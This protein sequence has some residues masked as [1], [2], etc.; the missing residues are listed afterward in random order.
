MPQVPT[1]TRENP[2]ELPFSERWGTIPLHCVLCKSMFPTQH[3]R[4]LYLLD[5]TQESPQ[6]QLHKSRMTLMSSKECEILRCNP[7]QFE[8][9]PQLSCTGSSAISHSP[10]YKTGCLSSFRQLQRF[11]DIPVSNLEE[12]QFQHRNWRKAPWTPYNLGKRADSQDSIEEVGQFSTSTSRVPFPQQEVCE[13]VP[14]FAASS[15]VDTEMPW[16]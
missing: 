16:L 8:I 11:P 4:S 1:A 13:R 14:E 3:E 2:W 6:E 7:N 5:G 15:R 9:T 10:S 12:H